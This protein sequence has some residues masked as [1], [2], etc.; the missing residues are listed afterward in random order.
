MKQ[1]FNLVILFLSFFSFHSAVQAKPT[2]KKVM[3]VVFENTDY[4]AAIKQPFFAEFAKVGA[5]LENMSALTHP[6]QGNYVS[7]ISGETYKINNDN[8]IDLNGSHIAD[9][10][11]AKKLSW[12]VY[13]EDYPGNCFKGEISGDYV[14]KHI[15]FMS[16][17]NVS[18]NPARCKNIVNASQLESD[19]NSESLSNYSMY[20][21]NLK[22][23]GHDTGVAFANQWFAKKFGPLMKDAKFMNE[24][25][26]IV[27][28]DEA[29]SHKTN[30]IYT[31]L[32]GDSVIAGGNSKK[33][34]NHYSILK[35]I[36]SAWDL[37]SLNQQDAKAEALTDV[38]K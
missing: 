14:R 36:E 3:I 2:F 25:L 27:T 8:K 35:T 24:M 15:P 34:Y 6:S 17:K 29:A 18:T 4:A 28:F 21:P 26:L 31:A 12:K 1:F 23:D 30:Q 32:Y 9:L 11:E 7:M 5:N 13:A 22:N 10:L 33:A 37:G 19:I 38:L 20:V 16:F